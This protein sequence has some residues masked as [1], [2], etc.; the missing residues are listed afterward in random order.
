M[1][2]ISELTKLIGKNEVGDRVAVEIQRGAE[3]LKLSVALG[4]WK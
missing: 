2:N 3:T 1:K 4:D